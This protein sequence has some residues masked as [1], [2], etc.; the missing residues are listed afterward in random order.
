MS[1]LDNII[2][3]MT[4]KRSIHLAVIGFPASGKSYL[5]SDMIATLAEMGYESELPELTFQ[6]S[7]FGTFYYDAFNNDTGGMKQTPPSACRPAN[8]YGAVMRHKGTSRRIAV[9]FLNIPGETFQD[10]DAQLR[11]YYNLR[12]ALQSIKGKGLLELTVWRNPSGKECYLLEPALSVRGKYKLLSYDGLSKLASNDFEGNAQNYRDWAM[13]YSELNYYQY[14]L[15]KRKP[16]S[17]NYV[18][19]H[20]F[21]LNT[22]SVFATIV[23]V[24][25]GFANGLDKMEYLTSNAFNDFYY[26]HYCSVATD[27]VICDKVFEPDGSGDAS[28]NFLSMI[29]TLQDLIKG[30]NCPK[31]YMAFRGADLMLKKCVEAYKEK[32]KSLP[33]NESRNRAYS[34]FES[35]IKSVYHNGAAA[36]AALLDVTPR[37]FGISSGGDLRSH[38]HNRIGGDNAHGFKS[39]IGVSYG[40]PA[41]GA[42]LPPHVYFTATPID[43]HFEI[44]NNDTLDATRFV[45]CQ[46]DA[47][48]NKQWKAFHIEVTRGGKRQFCF[49]TYQLMC[50]ILKQNNI[51]M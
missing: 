16:V 43:E 34:L 46:T 51:T 18:L 7:S 2:G 33:L 19:K 40:S 28:Y 12:D 31:V 38:L 9:D 49:G 24:W 3:G 20:F 13:I 44:Y 23:D 8:H 15:C 1:V 14:T 26:M 39:L 30:E 45:L 47:D 17:G 27:L 32:C 22:D 50:D 21:E 36:D 37:G 10:A 6:H 5:L 48:G 25:Q 42:G 41:D 11:R 35:Q 4:G 29:E